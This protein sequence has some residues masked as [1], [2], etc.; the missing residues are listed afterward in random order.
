MSA[1]ILCD[2]DAF[3]WAGVFGLSLVHRGRTSSPMYGFGYRYTFEGLPDSVN[4]AFATLASDQQAETDES[5]P[6]HRISIFTADD[7]TNESSNVISNTF[8]LHGNSIQDDI[9]SHRSVLSLSP[10]TIAKLSNIVS[11]ALAGDYTA[12]SDMS[13][14]VSDAVSSESSSN[15]AFVK[16]TFFNSWLKRRGS[17]AFQKSQYVFRVT[18]VI[19]RRGVIPVLFGNV[20]EVYT[21]AQLKAE[22]GPTPRYV[23]ALDYIDTGIQPDTI[24]TGHTWGW[25]K[26]TPTLTTVAGNREAV[27][28][29][30]YLAEWESWI[31]PAL[32]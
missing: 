13:S 9:V 8:E 3:R 21:T 25:L 7:P 23:E 17:L 22:T 14:D 30:F 10:I 27:Q 15:Q 12:D 31:Y 26:Q 24:L 28:N 1:V 20:N 2:Q 5:G 29:E 16:N 18:T 19:S 4:A 32:T 6:I 11:K